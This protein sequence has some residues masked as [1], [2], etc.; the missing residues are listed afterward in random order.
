MIEKIPKFINMEKCQSCE[1]KYYCRKGCLFEQIKNQGPIE[2]LCVAYKY[3][4]SLVGKMSSKLKSDL[5]FRKI[6]KEELING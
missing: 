2:E 5:H 3:I 4:Y 6:I 1:V